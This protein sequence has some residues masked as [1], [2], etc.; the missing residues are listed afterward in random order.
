MKVKMKDH[1]TISANT[2]KQAVGGVLI[3]PAALETN[4]M[5]STQSFMMKMEHV[6]KEV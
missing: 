1:L 5:E 2:Q 4:C 6:K 3:P